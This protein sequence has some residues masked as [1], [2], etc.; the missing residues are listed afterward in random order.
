M[1]PIVV[2][3]VISAILGLVTCSWVILAPRL[4]FASA[5]LALHLFG[6]SLVGASLALLS[7]S[8]PAAADL[9]LPA[10]LAFVMLSVPGPLLLASQLAGREEGRARPWIP[11]ALA[12]LV[13]L[14]TAA[15]LFLGIADTTVAQP[16]G[17]TLSLSTWNIV[18]GTLLLVS[19]VTFLIQVERILRG[20]AERQRWQLKFALLGLA[21]AALAWLYLATKLL[22]YRSLLVSDLAVFSYAFLITA[23]LVL[24]GWRRILGPVRLRLSQQAAYGSLTLSAV[25]IYLILTSLAASWVGTLTGPGS[26]I[27]AFVFLLTLAFLVTLLLSAEVRSRLKAWLRRNLYSGRYDYRTFWLEADEKIRDTDPL[28]VSA[29]ALA[30]LVARAL[31]SLDVSVWLALPQLAKLRHLASVGAPEIREDEEIEGVLSELD[32]RDPDEGVRSSEGIETPALRALLE[33]ARAQVFLPLR[34]GG[35]VVGLLTAGPDASRTPFDREAYEFLRALGLHAATEIRSHQLLELKLEAREAEAFN[36]FATFVLHDL[37]NFAST[38]SLVARNASS[39]GDNPEFLRDAFDS[40]LDTSEKMKRLCN[41]LNLFATGAGA[42]AEPTE[43]NRLVRDVAEE[44]RGGI[45]GSLELELGKLPPLP[46]DPGA[47]RSVVRNLVMN[48]A[49]AIDRNGTIRVVTTA[50][51]RFVELRVEDDGRGIPSAFLE[52]DL[53]VPFR[54][55]KSEGL[56]IGLFQCKRIVTA[57]GGRIDATSVEGRATTFR[58]QLPIP[59]R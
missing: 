19:A 7:F 58:V 18:L 17:G 15:W 21:L 23:L 13:P 59:R 6:G 8:G 48:A 42:E 16:G 25:G 26:E 31:G 49:E 43:L 44:L 20:S 4:G 56:G 33:R 5:W 38:L 32:D 24:L 34:A 54:T 51:E 41:S 50:G 53:F 22:L 14:T 47:M 36:S 3:Q 9:I 10:A 46:L 52:K 29:R 27:A 2:L 12:L 57:H 55:T 35:E 11:V 1:S 39:H 45:E 37:K 30:D 28:P 40:V